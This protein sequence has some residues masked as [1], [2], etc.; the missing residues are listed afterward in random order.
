MIKARIRK[1][2]HLSTPWRATLLSPSG[3]VLREFYHKK[4]E[5]AL[6]WAV[7]WVDRAAKHGG[8]D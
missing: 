3:V 8:V 6:S 5:T 2:D 7:E 1:H 4:H